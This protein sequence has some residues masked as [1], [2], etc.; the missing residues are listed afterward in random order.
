[1]V[2]ACVFVVDD[3]PK[4]GELFANV[5]RRDGYE[6]RA[7][8]H[9]Q[10]MLEA[11]EAGEQPDVVL[12][13]LMMPEINGIELL[14]VF[15]KRRL[16]VP[17]IIM[18]AH[19]SIQTAVEAMRL[20]A[21][22]YLQKPINL[23]E[24]RMLLKKALNLY[25]RDPVREQQRLAGQQAYPI[26]GILGES[27]AIRRV[28]QTIEM[29]RDVP[30]TI[31]LIRGETGTGKN[32]VARTIHHNSTYNAGRFVEIN[33]AALPDN[34]LEAELFGYEKGAF[35]DAR[36]SKPGLLEVADGGTVFLD[37]ID[38][39]SLALQAKL[40]SFL[41]SRTFRRL[42]GI[43]DIRVTT[44]I[45][46][47]TNVNLDQLV[48]ER[49][50]RQDLFYRINVVNLYLPPLR[51]MGRDI[52]LIAQAFVRQFNEQLGRNI[53]GFTPE[54]EQK[55]L[56]HSW[57]GNVRELRNVLERAMIFTKK[58]W[59]DAA[60]LHFQPTKVMFSLP[61]SNGV[62]YFPTGSTLEELEKAYILHTLKH[63]KASYAEVAQILGISK[64]TL[65]EKRKRYN[66][67]SEIARL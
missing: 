48:A 65:W 23:E 58:T 61:V 30:N 15:R 1:M 47:A 66:L 57:P 52:L 6:V 9:P 46:C 41:E 11:I 37:E 18:T 21:F 50:F 22:H 20:G 8:V 19:S 43:E 5:L 49:K 59:I 25:E 55:L 26:S 51:E 42:G 36:A 62:F 40:L 14:E 45:L 44:R 38:S 39:M 60:D 29:L 63:Y 24:M 35:T 34:L 53:K 13:D 10:V 64:K 4:M 28:R 67:D 33:C 12:A 7:F 16:N 17:I 54:A 3:E 31:V 2:K 27:E 32:L 56:E